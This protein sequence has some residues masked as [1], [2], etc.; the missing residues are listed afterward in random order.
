MPLLAFSVP[1]GLA[2]DQ[3]LARA[4][5]A[6]EGL[7]EDFNGSDLWIEQEGSQTRF[8]FNVFMWSVKGQTD[9]T[10]TS[11]DVRL[12]VPA[13]AM[14]MQNQIQAAIVKHLKEAMAG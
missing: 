2:V 3:L 6:I 14:M 12:E 11:V 9:A 10:P 4:R 13:A 8:S 5:P 7:V 1:H